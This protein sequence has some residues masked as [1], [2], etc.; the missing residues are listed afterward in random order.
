[1]AGAVHDR[2]LRRPALRLSAVLLVIASCSCGGA[3]P[4]PSWHW[5]WRSQWQQV[6][7]AERW[8]MGLPADG[9]AIVAERGQLFRATLLNPGGEPLEAR[10][11]GPG[12]RQAWSVPPG[13]AVPVEAVLA[14]RGAFSLSAGPGLML[15]S[16]RLG[17]SLVAPRLVVLVVVDTLRDDSV[18]PT[19]TPGILSAFAG[20]LRFRD[21]SANCSW[22]LPSM[23]SLFTSRPV[24]DLT[25]PEGD[26]LGVPEGLLTWASQLESSGFMGAAVVANY[27]VHVRNGF[28]QGFATY[29]VPDGH[30]SAQHPDAAWVVSEASRWLEHHAGEDAFLYL[31][32]MDPHEPYRDHSG[33]GRQP[34]R[35]APLAARQRFATA[36]E[37][38]LLREL[39]AGEV[40]HVDAVL[41]PFLAGLPAN[42]VVA[43]TADH[44][45][46]L[47][48]H[49]CWGHGP[50]LFQEA[51]AVPLLLRG[52]GVE[53]GT[54]STPVQLLDLTPTLLELAGCPADGQMLGRSL[55][56]GGS[57]EPA[58]SATFSAGPLR[59]SW[60]SGRHKALVHLAAQPG[61]GPADRNSYAE[62]EP[63]PAGAWV[64]DLHADPGEEHA[65][66]LEGELLTASGRAFAETTGRMVPGLQVMLWGFHGPAE[67]AV[68]VDDG[69]QLAQA[70]GAAPLELD[71]DGG[72]LRLRCASSFPVCGFAAS[73]DPARGVRPLAGT[74]PWLSVAGDQP[75][76]AESLNRP[77]FVP[78]GSAALWWNPPRD[79][80]VQAHR[81]TVEKLRALGYLR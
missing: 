11:S 68:H 55:L 80:T 32:L 63:L 71:H 67:L 4:E 74:A 43:F 22:T 72:E 40:R 52:P 25:T 62:A 17:R 56:A 53:P 12:L 73:T 5:L 59:W 66:P 19:L 76:A 41:S 31:H 3:S 2:L 13:A 15:G 58:V 60:R 61:L 29:L 39:Y 44:G 78:P 27:T 37:T 38:A 81:E 34:P 9:R 16:P 36:A 10:L 50:T 20:G 21:T 70:W 42:A 57:A 51:V 49:A 7:V 48:E 46:L 47:G 18:N 14:R 24:L 8:E 77:P 54:V 64:F 65:Q 30:G 1:M 69:A 79:R 35:L 26:L 75:L 33:A 23:A 45:E 6:H 28:G